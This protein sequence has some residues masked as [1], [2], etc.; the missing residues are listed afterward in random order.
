MI[1]KKNILLISNS[2]SFRKGYLEHCREEITDFMGN[3]KDILFVPYALKDYAMYAELARKQFE[4]M[5]YTCISLHTLRNKIESIKKTSCIFVGGG[6]TF[7]LLNTLY[8]LKLI[9]SIK[10]AVKNGAKYMGSSA[11]SNIA[12]PTIKT[13]NDMPIIQ[14]PSFKALNLVPFQINPHFIDSS[15]NSTHM[16]ETREQRLTEYLEENSIPVVALREGSWLRI[17][18]SK[19]TLGGKTGGI[20][21]EA[22]KKPYEINAQTNLSFLLKR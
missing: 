19:V 20:I 15:P 12:G 17:Q 18:N 2:K 22:Q 9:D 4:I 13:T 21:F 8:K 6:N 5:G 1:M 3:A 14:P 16:G 11:G 10:N 7:R